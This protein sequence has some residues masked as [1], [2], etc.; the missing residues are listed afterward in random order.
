MVNPL[1]VL[2]IGKCTIY[3]YQDVIDPITHRT[4]QEEVA[5]VVDEP[6]RVSYTRE[7]STNINNGL[8]EVAQVTM[9]FIR[10][11]LEIKPGSVIEVTQNGRTTKYKGASKT[12]LYTNHQE[13]ILELYEGHA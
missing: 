12:A 10:P 1:S 7:S 2:W 13:V 4:S 11:D 8:A 3:E 9:L 5:V 6:C